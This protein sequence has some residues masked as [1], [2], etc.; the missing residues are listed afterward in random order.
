[1]LSALPLSL[2]ATALVLLLLLMLHLLLV[3]I[4]L[5]LL[6][7]LLLLLLL[8]HLALRP[9]APS[10]H[11]PLPWRVLELRAAR[12]WVRVLGCGLSVH[13]DCALRLWCE[14]GGKSVQLQ[15][16]QTS[17]VCRAEIRV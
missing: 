3:L 13:F 8:L 6:L 16:E 5:L 15:A 1:L 14:R 10:T 2:C 12:R 4:P 17:K 9:L 7:R 11:L